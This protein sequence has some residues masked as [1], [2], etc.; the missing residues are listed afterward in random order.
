MD[1]QKTHHILDTTVDILKRYMWEIDAGERP[2]I[3]FHH[4]EKLKQLFDFDIGTSWV[5][6]A[7]LFADIQS[8]LDKSV[9]T[10]HPRFF[11][12]LY[13]WAHIYSIV[14]EFV[15]AVLNT[16]M[17]T[18]EVWPVF[19]LMEEYI[20]GR[21]AHL[22]WWTGVYDGMMLPGWS[23]A[24]LTAMQ[25]ARYAHNPEIHTS[26][27]YQSRPLVILTSDESH[28]SITKSAMLMG[29]WK[30]A[31]VKI[32][33]DSIW[34]MD[35]THL[36]QTIK[37]VQADWKDVYMI[38]ATSWT[39]V[40]WAYDNIAEIS[41]IAKKYDIRVHV[42]MI[43]WGS[44][45]FSKDFMHKIDWIK[46]V[47][48]FSWNP[49]KMIWANLQCS[50]LMTQRPDVTATCNVLK[51]QYLFQQDKWYDIWCDTWDKYTQCWRRVDVLKL[52]LLWRAL[53]DTG[54]AKIVDDAFAKAAYLVQ[55]IHDAD[56]LYLYHDPQ[57]TNVNFRY[58]P[59]DI[60]LWEDHEK[61]LHTIRSHIDRIHV[62][63]AKIKDMMLERWEMMTWYAHTK[64][65]PNFF[66]MVLISPKVMLHDID[67]VVTHIQELGMR[68]DP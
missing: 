15:I 20:F 34:S 28:Y 23:N 57:C 32:Q 11:N 51:T 44:V 8:I 39:T 60:V 42:D 14:A 24:N 33:T 27:L 19:T 40:M 52:R 13:A 7:T 53:W 46:H 25:L 63:T 17:Y 41:H 4:P 45:L 64:W 48:S 56:R 43:R 58:I 18:Y 6:E 54:I 21:I 65:Y 55:K 10:Q 59:E 37:E 9:A 30:D 67:F 22:V 62:L 3:D 35:T 5:D 16:S 26:W 2:V 38:N 31:V 1:I 29:L 12:Q 68:I 66:R 50:I 47:D 36:E 61:N 49:H